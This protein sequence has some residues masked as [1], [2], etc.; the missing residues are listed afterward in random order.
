[1]AFH[2][3]C[4]ITCQ[5]I[6]FCTLG[7]P[8]PLRTED[9]RRDF[10]EDVCRLEELLPD[11]WFLRAG[12]RR[13]V[14]V[15][16]PRVNVGA[17]RSI[18]HGIG[19]NGSLVAA[20]SANGEEAL[21]LQMKRVAMQKKAVEASLAAEDYA[22]RL[23]AGEVP[24]ASGE[25]SKEVMCRL[26]Y[27][28]EN[29]GSDRAARMLSCRNCSK[30]YH[31]T[32]LKSWAQHRDLFDW[33]SWICPFCRSCE[34]CRKIGDPKKFMFC[35]RCDRAYHS[36]CQ[37]PPHKN[38]SSGPYLCPNH[39]RCHSCGSTVPGNGPS[40]R[41]FLSYT[42]CDAC[43]RLFVKGNY[44]PV[45]LKVYRDS[46]PTPMVCCDVCQRWVHCQCDG[47]SDE[48]YR[49][50]QADTNL[51]YKCAAC[52]GDCYQ[53]KDIDDAIQELWKRR[54]LADRAQIA[55]LRA[56]AGLTQDAVSISP[57]SDD[58]ECH[59]TL[60]RNEGKP[61]KFSFKGLSNSKEQ[62][63]SCSKNVKQYKKITKKKDMQVQPH[64]TVNL[65]QNYGLLLEEKS[66]QDDM[67][68]EKADNT[69]SERTEGGDFFVPVSPAIGAGNCTTN[70][71]VEENM[72]NSDDRA[73]KSTQIR[74]TRL[75]SLG[76]EVNQKL[77]G[78]SET[79]KGKKLVIHLGSRN[80][81]A[82]D[83]PKLENSSGH[84]EQDSSTVLGANFDT[85]SP[86]K[87][88][89]RRSKESSLFKCKVESD[90]DL[91]NHKVDGERAIQASESQP[92]GKIHEKKAKIETFAVVESESASNNETVLWRKNSN[93]NAG[94]NN[95]NMPSPSPMTS[96]P[97]LKVKFK[98][99]S[100]ENRN[101]WVSQSEEET[102]NLIK[103]QRSKRKRPSLMLEK[104][105]VTDD[106][107]SN[108]FLCRD[109]PVDQEMDARILKKLG[110]DAVGKEVE[111]YEALDNSWHRGVVIGTVQ[112]TSALSVSL[113]DGR[114]VTLEFGKHQVR[115]IS[116]K[117]KLSKR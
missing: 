57:Y 16:V 80:R 19:E 51:Y 30:K 63:K 66:L 33:S 97:F 49:Q 31:R 91:S 69:N 48:K 42:C 23:E 86:S 37:H 62:G 5:R 47:I 21:S 71:V 46:E 109:N 76:Y 34:A 98:T 35:K 105:S 9:G 26:C 100:L 101:S 95:Q 103:G 104:G 96:K 56:A 40:T 50:F 7:F 116:Q 117:P 110:K 83:T 29:E 24:D 20:G 89:I 107:S 113:D 60:S 58:E 45:C 61:L 54:D 8:E 65:H 4:P 81:I 84:R 3:A 6:C 93:T 90:S 22:R 85:T 99:L 27:S 15:A 11:P 73:P 64:G 39:T 92:V 108:A 13:T 87:R 72:V 88:L 25:A 36:Y 78:Q 75:N 43:G 70:Q 102:K 17:G 52:R 2:V 68:Y 28:G 114:D 112:G 55:S 79:G 111:V 18:E 77:S 1:M 59:V 82:A 32:C 74:H 10:L 67:I 12:C 115:F 106:R 14:Q 41:W 94:G 53:V 38:V 44:C